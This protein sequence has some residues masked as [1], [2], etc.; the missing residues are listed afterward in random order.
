MWTFWLL[1]LVTLIV[2]AEE[3]FGSFALSVPGLLNTSGGL[4]ILDMRFWY[5]PADAYQLFGA[6]GPAG[7]SA[8]LLLY[9]TVDILIPLLITM[10]LW[11]TISRGAL[12][13]FRGLSLL[14]GVFDYLENIA[15]TIL[16]VRYPQHLDPLVTVAACFT[17]LKFVFYGLG[18][19][20]AIVGF[21]I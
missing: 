3:N 15:I 8:N 11:S 6:L 4:P 18:I 2:L 12:R 20:M 21:V 14:G 16:L 13:R 17:V 19:L 9:L 1:L 10:L 5:T 7:R